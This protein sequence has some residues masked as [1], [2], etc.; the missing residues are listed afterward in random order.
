ILQVP[1]LHQALYALD[2]GADALFLQGAEAGGHS[3]RRASFPLFPAVRDAV[4]KDVV[5]VG[6]GGIADGRVMAAALALG[7][8]AEMKG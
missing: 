2:A 5:I 6:A 1:E 8:D 7:M 3:L 4:G